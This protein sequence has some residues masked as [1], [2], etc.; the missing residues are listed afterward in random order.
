MKIVM[1]A[2]GSGGHIYPAIQLADSLKKDHEIIFFG[3][4]N[5]LEGEIIPALGYEFLSS[6]TN[7][8][9][10]GLAKKI[11]SL[12]LMID[13]YQDA[14]AKLK[15]IKPDLVIGFGNFVSVPVVKAAQKL[16]IRTII[17]EQNRLLGSANNY[18]AKKANAIVVSYPE[19]KQKLPQ[20]KA[21]Y[22]GNPR[23]SYFKN[24][25]IDRSVLIKYD[26]NPLI[27]TVLF[28]M[29]SQGSKSINDFMLEVLKEL[30]NAK[31]QILYVTG[32]AYYDSFKDILKDN[33]NIKIRDYVEAGELLANIDVLVARAGATTICEITACGIPSILIPSP[34]VPNNHQY[35]N[36]QSLVDKRAALLVNEKDLDV[37]EFI[38]LLGGLI[39]D[40]RERKILAANAKKLGN[41]KAC[42]DFIKLIR[43]V[44]KNV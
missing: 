6:E 17:H 4:N 20:E 31:F 12:L 3:N 13:A 44:V 24:I 36:A 22:L 29:G 43:R 33:K 16:G 1:V 2:G 11:N 42:D 5:R 40:N 26:L 19:T 28:F 21:F 39:G 41:T 35:F 34:F 10:G 15:K 23:S 25:K 32:K 38:A 9:S 8:F 14:K 7:N 37:K 27:P 18:L 30:K